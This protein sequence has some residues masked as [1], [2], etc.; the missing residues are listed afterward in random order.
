MHHRIK[1]AP[2]KK[3][4]QAITIRQ[5]EVDKFTYPRINGTAVPGDQGI[6]HR[7]VVVA[8]QQI[9]GTNTADITGT[10]GNKYLFHKSSFAVI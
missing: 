3:R 8:I 2:L 7:N 1:L 5:I 6:Q 4:D 9:F 10:A